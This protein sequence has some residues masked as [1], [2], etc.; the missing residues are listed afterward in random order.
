MNILKTLFVS[1][2]LGDA[3][4]ICPN[5]KC[6]DF[7]GRN[8]SLEVVHMNSSTNWFDAARQ[9]EN[10]RGRLVWLYDKIF[11]DFITKTIPNAMSTYCPYCTIMWL[12][13]MQSTFN[14]TKF[15]WK[16]T[17]NGKYLSNES[18]SIIRHQGYKT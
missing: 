5:D 15:F 2:C 12:G 8:S 16:R 4:G 3:S 1:A 10:N 6:V 17:V 13:L 18:V 11:T 14:D 7:P 9:C